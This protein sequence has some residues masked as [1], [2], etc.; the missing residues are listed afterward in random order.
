MQISPNIDPER[1]AFILVGA[2]A[3]GLVGRSMGLAAGGT[4]ISGA[5]PLAALGAYAGDRI[6]R[7]TRKRPR[8][9]TG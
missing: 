6:W 9:I 3:A 7:A 8:P 1:A 5:I 4:A 2:C